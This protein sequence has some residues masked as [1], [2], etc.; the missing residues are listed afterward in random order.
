MPVKGRRTDAPPKAY[1]EW[2]DTNEHSPQ[3]SAPLAAGKT[4][5]SY[6]ASEP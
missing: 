4:R 1:R 5:R 6:A 3:P 2:P